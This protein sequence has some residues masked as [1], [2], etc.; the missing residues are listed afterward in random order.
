M[1]LN[2]FRHPFEDNELFSS[3]EELGEPMVPEHPQGSD[4]YEF[5]QSG[6]TV[7]RED[8][9]SAFEG[10]SFEDIQ[11][12]TRLNIDTTFINSAI[13]DSFANV[14][15]IR[16]DEDSLQVQCHNAGQLPM[17]ETPLKATGHN[18]SQLE[19]DGGYPVF[20]TSQ[21]SQ[22]PAFHSNESSIGEDTFYQNSTNLDQNS[23]D[24]PLAPSP[25]FST[26]F[27]EGQSLTLASSWHSEGTTDNASFAPVDPSARASTSSGMEATVIYHSYPSPYSGNSSVSPTGEILANTAGVVPFGGGFFVEGLV[28]QKTQSIPERPLGKHRR[29]RRC[30]L[31]G[32]EKKQHEKKLAK[33]RAK[34][35][36]ER[37]KMRDRKANADLEFEEERKR[38]LTQL[39]ESLSRM[40]MNCL[41]ICDQ[42]SISVPKASGVTLYSE[43]FVNNEYV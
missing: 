10:L 43:E 13:L 29:P 15:D 23:N 34:A 28:A 32:E 4:R 11:R 40:R 22:S 35:H 30:D 7:E 2:N 12:E 1:A 5:Q 24:Y 8:M 38:K 31:E 25:Y 36:A 21:M 37:E 16:Q 39:E 20:M 14:Q 9:E 3:E 27:K 42:Y 41:H 33:E 18:T 17:L 26:Q 19:S 6:A